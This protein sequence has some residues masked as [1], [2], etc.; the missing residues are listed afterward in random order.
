[1]AEG[2]P[3]KPRLEPGHY[4]GRWSVPDETGAVQRLD[5]DLDLTAGRPPTVSASGRVPL[6][7]EQGDGFTT[8][9]FPQRFTHPVIVG[10]LRNG[11]T[12]LLLD[13]EVETWHDDLAFINARA[14]LVGPARAVL[15]VPPFFDTITVQITG[16]DA[17]A[18]VGPI[19]SF[20]L[21]A[22]G[23]SFYEHLWQ[24]EPNPDST[25]TWADDHAELTLDWASAVAQE[26]AFFRMAFS[27]VAIVTLDEPLD[28]DDC[29]TM[30]IEPLRRI[31]SLAT[32][33]VED[34]TYLTL[35]RA[36]GDGDGEHDEFQVYGH[37]LDQ[38]PFATRDTDV[39]KIN[40]A[41]RATTEATSPLQ[42]LRVWQRLHDEHHPLLETYGASIVLPRQH[43]RS[44]YLLL[45]QALEGLFGHE[46]QTEHE[47]NVAAYQAKRDAAIAALEQVPDLPAPVLKFLRKYLMRKPHGGLDQCLTHMFTSLPYDVSEELAATTLVQQVIHDAG[48]TVGLP[49]ALRAVRNDLSHGTK[50]YPTM[51]LYAVV[52]ILDRV[53]RAHMLRVLGCGTDAQLKAARG[54]RP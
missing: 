29:L 2:V 7:A 20:T 44:T 6:A 42:M 22:S 34:I 23:Q 54:D 30:W 17:Y 48:E 50:G 53:A 37:K 26:L 1:M 11:P 36:A 32:G 49:A 18:G 21:P 28:V 33:R 13:A 40:A 46:H 35:S 27:P 25:Q 51:D 4:R 5:G 39:R 45:V 38:A 31:I 8:A 16:L 3:L 19:R 24:V 15:D 41:F 10:E 43:P 9:A 12:V 14:A 52:Q 47:E